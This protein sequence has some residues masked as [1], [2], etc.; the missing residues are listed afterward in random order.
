MHKPVLLHEVVSYL[1][2]REGESYLDLTAGYGGHADKI[3][4]VTQNY[5][6]AVLIDRDWNAVDYLRAKYREVKPEIA[7]DDFYN[8]ALRLV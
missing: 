3:L 1:A 5:K 7:H 8:A 4:E 2:P 6:G